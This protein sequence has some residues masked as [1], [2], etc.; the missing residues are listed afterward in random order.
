MILTYSKSL[1][2]MIWKIENNLLFKLLWQNLKIK[3]SLSSNH[4]CFCLPINKISFFLEIYIYSLLSLRILYL[5]R[6][7]H[8][9]LKFFTNKYIYSDFLSWKIIA[10]E[11]SLGK[12]NPVFEQKSSSFRIKE[13]KSKGLLSC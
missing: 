13:T 5:I 9:M 3:N 8:Y 2:K 10:H 6:I 4:E 7:S 1:Y 12:S 11:F